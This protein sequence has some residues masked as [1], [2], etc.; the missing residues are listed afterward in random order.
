MAKIMT[1][2]DWLTKHV[3]GTKKDV[4][5]IGANGSSSQDSTLFDPMMTRK[6]DFCRTK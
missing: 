2:L 5:A 6:F 1:Q 4:N 3:M